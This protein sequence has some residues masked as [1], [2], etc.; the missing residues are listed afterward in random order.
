MFWRKRQ[1]RLIRAC[2]KVS[3]AVEVVTIGTVEAVCS[4]DHVDMI[5]GTMLGTRRG[6]AEGINQ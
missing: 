3:G 1:G 5:S 4:A 2:S 6:R